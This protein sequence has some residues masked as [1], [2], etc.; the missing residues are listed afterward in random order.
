MAASPRMTA[1]T[2]DKPSCSAS[3]SQRQSFLIILTALPAF[4]LRAWHRSSE[5]ARTPRPDFPT[6]RIGERKRSRLHAFSL[7]CRCRC[8][9]NTV[10]LQHQVFTFS[11]CS[12]WGKERSRF[13]AFLVV[14]TSLLRK[15]CSS[16]NWR[17]NYRFKSCPD[18]AMY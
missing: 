8:C 4:A 2:H 16:V 18:L 1:N 12:D 6:V 15:S 13:R 3:S 10:K 11:N 7:S 5:A 9:A 14:S 17:K